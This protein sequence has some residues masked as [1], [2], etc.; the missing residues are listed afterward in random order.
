MQ[1]Q[2]AGHDLVISRV[3]HANTSWNGT[4]RLVADAAV[5]HIEDDQGVHRYGSVAPTSPLSI[6]VP[7]LDL[8]IWP[9][10]FSRQET[11][12]YQRKHV[13]GD[14][15]DS[16]LQVISKLVMIVFVKASVFPQ[17]CCCLS[18]ECMHSCFSVLL[19]VHSRLHAQHV[20]TVAK[21]NVSLNRQPGMGPKCQLNIGAALFGLIK[22]LNIKFLPNVI[23]HQLNAVTES[24]IADHRIPL[25][26]QAFPKFMT[27]TISISNS[28]CE[29]QRMNV[30]VRKN[31]T[32]YFF[33]LQKN[34][35]I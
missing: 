33:E 14:D 10:I 15:K 34:L 8:Q 27:V 32:R 18:T 21:T 24:A 29:W 7:T 13:F 4:A 3:G 19:C 6:V 28:V 16:M 11:N 1:A 17:S 35:H 5:M 30:D 22:L 25:T 2:V 31:W 23:T 20:K 26:S 9:H 12:E